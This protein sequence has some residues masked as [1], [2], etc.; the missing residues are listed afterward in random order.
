M[1]NEKEYLKL[2]EEGNHLGQ[3]NLGCC[4]QIVIGIIKYEKKAF[5]WYLKSGNH[6]GQ[7]NLGNCYLNEIGTTKGK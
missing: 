7:N 2:A 5:R 3:F 4:Y 6:K 1:K